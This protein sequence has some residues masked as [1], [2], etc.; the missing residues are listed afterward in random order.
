[1]I[2]A[3]DCACCILRMTQTLALNL[4]GLLLH[5]SKASY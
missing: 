3:V 4:L 5:S 1:M 2:G